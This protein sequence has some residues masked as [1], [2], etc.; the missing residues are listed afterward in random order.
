MMTQWTGTSRVECG[1]LSETARRNL[2]WQAVPHLRASNRKRSAANSGTV[3]RRLN[4]AVAAGREKS[5]ANWK[6]GNVSELAMVR[7]CTAVEHLVYQDGNFGPGAFGNT[8]PARLDS[9]SE[10]WSERRKLKF[11]SK[12]TVMQPHGNVQWNIDI[13]RTNALILS[14]SYISVSKATRHAVFSTTAPIGTP[15]HCPAVSWPV[16]R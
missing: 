15:L 5:S 4:E 3:S 13:R 8:H 14:Y 7:R 9:A 16:W 12:I 6:V 1:R 2:R 11:S 10:T